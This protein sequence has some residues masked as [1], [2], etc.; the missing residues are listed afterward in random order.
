V[1]AGQ[2]CG[3][4]RRKRGGW[5]GWQR[6]EGQFGVF[7]SKAG[8]VYF[9]KEQI[10]VTTWLYEENENVSVGIQKTFPKSKG[11]DESCWLGPGEGGGKGSDY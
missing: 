6:Y 2:R 4:K 8:L 10:V 5:G 3:R 1:A 11:E 7:V 9:V